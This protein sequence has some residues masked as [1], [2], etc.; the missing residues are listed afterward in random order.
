MEIVEKEPYLWY[1]YSMKLI[2]M[3]SIRSICIGLLGVFLSLVMYG[4][5]ALPASAQ[6]TNFI[7]EINYNLEQPISG[8]TSVVSAGEYLQLVYQLGLGLVGIIAVVII[9]FGGMLWVQAAGNEQSISK[10]KE[11]IISAVVGLLI[12]LL[13][14]TILAFINPETLRINFSVSRIPIVGEEEDIFKLKKCDE[15]PFAGEKCI[16]NNKTEVDCSAVSCGQKGFFN[17]EF[18]RGQIC[19]TGSGGCFSDPQN[20]TEAQSCQQTQC[21]DWIEKCKASEYKKYQPNMYISQELAIRRCVCGY[22]FEKNM[23]PL[24]AP[25]N[26]SQLTDNQRTNWRGFC[27][28]ETSQEQ[29]VPQ[30]S[31]SPAVISLNINPET[32]VWNCKSDVNR[33]LNC[34]F[35]SPM[36]GIGYGACLP[37]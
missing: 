6:T 31:A 20:P 37:Q 7:R 36:N 30:L 18:C 4:S 23:K 34:Q 1:N 29:L 2:C 15:A 5:V 26:L 12:A 32:I 14:Y 13:S 3:G 28:E 19:A 21:G 16:V 25:T 11:L 9:M 35:E 8:K 33:G 22:S 10:A 24:G 17:G 27:I